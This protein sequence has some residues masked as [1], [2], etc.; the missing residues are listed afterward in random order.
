MEREF[1]RDVN[2]N[3]HMV[4]KADILEDMEQLYENFTG[5]AEELYE[6]LYQ[7]VKEFPEHEDERHPFML[8]LKACDNCSFWQDCKDDK[9]TKICGNIKSRYFCDATD[10][11]W[12]CGEYA[13]ISS[14]E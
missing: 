13:D 14:K 5:T 12:Y 6:Q 4:Y 9:G 8:T 7:L 3:L 1:Y 2:E 10:P 11:D